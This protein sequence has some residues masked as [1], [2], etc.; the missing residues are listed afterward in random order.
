MR[1]GAAIARLTDWRDALV[2]PDEPSQGQV[3]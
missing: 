1:T 2:I 3:P